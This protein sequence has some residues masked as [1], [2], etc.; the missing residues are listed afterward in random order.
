[1]KIRKSG[2]LLQSHQLRYES[3][4]KL[5][6][7]LQITL[8]FVHIISAKFDLQMR[9]LALRHQIRK[10][11]HGRHHTLRNNEGEFAI[12]PHHKPGHCAISKWPGPVNA[13]TVPLCQEKWSVLENGSIGF[14]VG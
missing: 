5:A 13:L 4:Q 10:A 8:L 7:I 11:A 3:L 6:Q 2:K 12:R 14:L 9:Q 1:M